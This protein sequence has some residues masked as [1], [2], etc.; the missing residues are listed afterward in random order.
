M[1][2]FSCLEQV[3]RPAQMQGVETWILPL[4]GRSSKVTPQDMPVCGWEG[5]R[6]H[7]YKLLHLKLTSATISYFPS[8][9]TVSQ[10]SSQADYAFMITLLF[11]P[12]LQ[13]LVYIVNKLNLCVSW[14]G[15]L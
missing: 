14:P 13:L 5:I 1:F 11:V 8:P 4:G 12:F 7:S 3:T 15:P 10:L 6:G 9:F 2:L